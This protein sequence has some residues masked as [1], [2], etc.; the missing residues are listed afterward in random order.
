[1]SPS[2][3]LAFALAAVSQLAAAAKP[4]RFPVITDVKW[5]GTGCAAGLGSEA[6]VPRGDFGE[7]AVSYAL[8][9][10]EAY[11]PSAVKTEPVSCEVR[12]QAGSAPAGWKVRVK[13]IQTHSD[14]MLHSR[15][16]VNFDSRVRWKSDATEGIPV[17]LLSFF[18]R[19]EDG[20]GGV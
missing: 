10:I 18:P 15:N 2:T 6:V 11:G 5:S 20:L 9:A 1:M 3:K 4:E 12:I 14:V 17:R 8:F 7:M 19:L 16:A 13:A